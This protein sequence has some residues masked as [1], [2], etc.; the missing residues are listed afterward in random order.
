MK[1]MIL[2]KVIL[3]L[4]VIAPLI[5]TSSH[6]DMIDPAGNIITANNLSVLGTYSAAA[7]LNVMPGLRPPSR[8]VQA[9]YQKVYE[10]ARTLL[11]IGL[12]YRQNNLQLIPDCSSPET[13]HQNYQNFNDG[14]LF[15]GFCSDHGQIDPRGYCPGDDPT[16]WPDE[17]N[18]IRGQLVRAREMYGFLALAEPAD[19]E[20]TVNGQ[21]HPVRVLGRTGVLSATREIANI[22]MVFGNEFLVDA[23]DYRFGGGDPRADQIINQELDQLGAARQQ[24]ELAVGVLAHAFNAD[25][26]GASGGYIGDFFGE[27]EFDLFGIVSERLVLSINEIADR[28]RQQGN[29]QQALDL[30]AEA[31]A[32][33][34]VQAMALA[35]SAGE[36]NQDFLNSGGFEIINNLEQLRSRAQTIHDGVNP[37][38]YVDS[39][40]PLQTYTELR[41]L[42]RSDFLRDAAE[43]ENRAENAQREFDRNSTAL[44]TELQNLRQTYDTRLLEICG[45][46]QDDYETCEVEGGLMMQ[47]F[48]N[49]ESASL[50]LQQVRQRQQNI[51]EQIEI[52]QQRAGQVIQLTLA[53]GDSIAATEMARGVINAVRETTTDVTTSS[54]D[55]HAG[56]EVRKEAGWNINP[57]KW[58]AGMKL[59][60]SAGYRYSRSKIHSTTT[61]YDPAQEELA[62]LG[63]LQA[64][65]NAL[66]QAQ[67][68][69]ANSEATIRNLQLQIVE[70]AIE[71]E[72]AMEEW[73]RL[74]SVHNDLVNQ[75]AHWR[76][77]RL[78]AQ[79]NFLDSYLNNPAYRI[80]RDQATVE[81]ARSV[82][83]AAQF[84]YLSAKAL[85]YEFLIR[86]PSL[87]D[88]FKARTADD[89]DNF[90]NDLEAFRVALGS[91]GERNRYPYRISLAQDI[92]GLSDEN[93]NP[94][95]S[96]NNSQVAQ[97]R[98]ERFQGILQQNMVTDP[99]TGNVVA[100]EIPFTTSLLDN[101]IFTPNVWNNRIAGVGLPADVPNTQGI[102][103]NILTRQFGDIGTPEVQ[104]TH[105][106]HASYR[107]ATGGIVEYVPENAKLSGYLIPQ[108]FGSKSKTATILSSVNGN[109]QGTPSSALF[110]R[111]VAT[112]NW[113]VRIDLQSP[114]NTQIDLAQLEDIEIEMDTTGVA[115]T[116]NVQAAQ[117]DAIRLQAGFAMPSAASVTGR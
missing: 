84:A 31:F 110:N 30:Y 57:L 4:L 91:P 41:T 62:K 51:A 48:H 73:N 105:S 45:V 43:D 13:C 56:V 2:H 101:S 116:T 35:V 55:V 47:N 50:R 85:E 104:L 17:D 66:T 24:F 82:G 90:M 103:V 92:Y 100:I 20:I 75:Y 93:L 99:N 64:L 86:Y 6:A 53:N 27:R 54:H 32:T 71:Y 80:L 19:M 107:T 113:T 117:A 70:L 39:Y 25:F 28:Y 87:G 95:G 78:K 34:Y 72:I 65:Q 42:I 15:Y 88:V 106:G 1:M 46:S 23:M 115:L 102:S 3:A 109:Q 108:G 59:I 94:D 69:G 52:E 97:L 9:D 58:G 36:Q 77:L 21:S 29:D 10:Q 12:T 111:S 7:E 68:A 38:G 112:S 26:G 40:V 22:H 8:L 81:A 114:F 98:L 18:S 63:S 61:V 76:N 5:P 74:A 89:I 16:T 83:F 14:D 33:Q 44:N 67:I 11:D 60:A 49:M 96:L 37:F 79:D